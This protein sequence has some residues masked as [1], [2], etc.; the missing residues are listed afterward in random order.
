MH[1]DRESFGQLFLHGWLRVSDVEFDVVLIERKLAWNRHASVL[2]RDAPLPSTVSIAEN[3]DG[4]PK[5][6]MVRRDE[7]CGGLRGVCTQLKPVDFLDI[8]QFVWLENSPRAHNVG[9]PGATGHCNPDTLPALAHA[10]IGRLNHRLIT[11]IPSRID[12]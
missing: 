5:R 7:R 11:G 3:F 4:D 6:T 9:M 1:V 12:Q 8:R 10:N 2:A